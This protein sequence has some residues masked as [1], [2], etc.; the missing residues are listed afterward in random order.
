MIR[1][2]AVEFEV[3]RHQLDGQ[4][5]EDGGDGV[6][7]HTVAGVDRDLE[8]A[9]LRQVDETA[10]ERRVVLE[11]VAFGDAAALAVVFRNTGDEFGRDPCEARVLPDRLGAGAAELDPVVPGRIVAGGEHRAGRVEQPGGEVE[12]VGGREPD[13]HHVESLCGDPLGE[14]PRQRGRRGAHVVPDHH[15]VRGALTAHQTCERRSDIADE[16]FVDLLPDDSPDVVR[17]DDR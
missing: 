6:P 7:A 16:L 12:L 14:R 2:G 3:E 15:A 4:D 10:D 5:A 9:H 8:R 11:D 17:L 1:E 13:R